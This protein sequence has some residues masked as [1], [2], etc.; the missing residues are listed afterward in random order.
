MAFKM[1]GS[2][3]Y[4]KGNQSNYGKPSMAKDYDVNKGSHGH[5]HEAPLKEHAKGHVTKDGKTTAIN[6]VEGRDNE[7]GQS[8]KDVI[9]SRNKNSKTY[10]DK[11]T[12]FAEEKGGLT[13]EQAKKANEKAK[14]LDALTRSSMDSIQ[15]VNIKLDA[16]DAKKRTEKKKLS[17]EEFNAL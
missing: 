17:D 3:M 11:V 16:E 12:N 10:A 13:K 5:P 6:V 14:M 8:Q 15:G 7:K 1:K 2:A 9:D 4:G